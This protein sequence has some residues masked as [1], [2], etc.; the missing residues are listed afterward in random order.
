MT[1]TFSR[2][3]LTIMINRCDR[4]GSVGYMGEF[5]NFNLPDFDIDQY[6]KRFHDANVIIDASASRI[7]YPEHWSGL[8]IK[9]AFNG[10]EN[11]RTPKT[12]YRV[13]DSSFL[14]FN[15]GNL[16]SSWI[17]HTKPVQSFTLNMTPAFEREATN[18]LL[19]SGSSMLD[20]PHRNNSGR[21]H[22]LECLYRHD[23]YITKLMMQMRALAKDLAINS[24]RLEEMYFDLF[25]EMNSIQNRSHAKNNNDLR[26]PARYELYQR[27][28]RARDL[29]YSCFNDHLTL[30]DISE[31]ACL[32][33]FHF[34][35]EFKKT[36]RK[37]PH[38]FLTEVRIG[39][40]R[41]KL[42]RTSDTLAQIC[43][44]VGYVDL[45][46]FSKLFKRITGYAPAEY[47]RAYSCKES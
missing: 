41:E 7:Y 22:F 43:G 3:L 42:V 19:C 31:V 23:G 30:A 45:T 12:H 18:A 9:C 39:A 11:Y 17:D 35:R 2:T 44:D 46:S 34:L 27:L 1:F 10:S 13:D 6:N 5:P 33:K 20:D 32:N 26:Q 14:V 4:V 38:E 8:S 47:R 15:E 28:L 36:F 37:T 16:Y 29:M 25:V 24:L 40:A 21:I